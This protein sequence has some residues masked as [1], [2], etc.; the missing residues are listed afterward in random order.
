MDL[1]QKCQRLHLFLL[2]QFLP[3]GGNLA[4]EQRGEFPNVF[5]AEKVLE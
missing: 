5:A 3:S 1:E 4:E 2:F